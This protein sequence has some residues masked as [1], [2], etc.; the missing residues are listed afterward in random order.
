MN[1]L[2]T[3]P[4]GVVI[5][6]KIGINPELSEKLSNCGSYHMKEIKKQCDKIASWEIVDNDVI[7]D[8]KEFPKIV[9][10]TSVPFDE[11]DADYVSTFAK[12]QEQ[13]LTEI[14]NAEAASFRIEYAKNTAND[15]FKEML[16]LPHV[17][18]EEEYNEEN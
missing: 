11:V 14:I 12:A 13:V 5:E 2:K 15:V 8:D 1:I 7:L 6:T 10:L 9:K 3:T 4:K 16:Y 18:S 17:G